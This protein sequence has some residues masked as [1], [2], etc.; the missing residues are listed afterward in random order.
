[1]HK[2]TLSALWQSEVTGTVLIVSSFALFIFI[3]LNFLSRV[4][5]YPFLFTAYSEL[6]CH[7]DF[8]FQLKQNE[9]KD[10]AFLLAT[11]F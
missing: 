3:F 2:Y 8:C 6:N 5:H 10:C 1:M 9:L 7:I 4:V 11:L